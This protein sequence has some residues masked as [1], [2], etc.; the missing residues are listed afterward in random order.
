MP[1]Y[2]SAGTSIK[3]HHKKV[4]QFSTPKA[5]SSASVFLNIHKVPHFVIFINSYSLKKPL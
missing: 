1:I 5:S 4:P 3:G 2:E